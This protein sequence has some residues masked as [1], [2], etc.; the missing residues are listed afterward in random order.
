M[1]PLVLLSLTLLVAPAAAQ[2]SRSIPAGRGV[3]AGTV[4][5]RETGR[6]L[7]DAIV[8]LRSDSN[9]IL[10]TTSDAEG[11]YMFE[12]LAAGGYRVSADIDGYAHQQFRVFGNREWPGPGDLRVT[13]EG[14]KIS[15]GIAWLGLAD[16]QRRHNV[17]LAMTRG[18]HLMGRV[19]NADGRPVKDA[20]VTAMFM[21]GDGGFSITERT[22]ARTNDRGEY[23]LR[24]IAPGAYTV[25]AM[26]H[27]PDRL[28]SSAPL[29]TRPTFF[30]GTS[31]AHEAMTITVAGGATVRNI[32]IPLTPNDLFRVSGH[33]LRARSE[34]SI[35][36][37][38][39]SGE[40]A[41]RSVRVGEDGAFD[42]T[43][44]PPG[45]HTLW[46][47]AATAD[48]WEAAH[49]DLSLGSDMIGLVLP[50]TPTGTI[51]GRV[52][53]ED[54]A[55]F[56]GDGTQLIADLVDVEG[57]R[58]DALPRDRVDIGPDGAFA[59]TGMFGHRKLRLS[60][61]DF[62]VARV[63]VEK[64]SVDVL[65]VA[66]DEQIDQVLVVIQKKR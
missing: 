45:R 40:A 49:V 41:V 35:E 39:L 22:H 57:H 59:L 6:P 17:D 19:T 14:Y 23:V 50:M 42:V 54:G 26:W 43:H 12:G 44:I 46:A 52:V 1:L 4:V 48:G 60:G 33:V 62:A 31:K 47:R 37:H 16:G 58:L 28:K 55:A 3:I 13:A 8:T 10:K 18:G 9:G 51:V 38:L 2:D 32:D 24:D 20:Q 66:S 29:T 21:L 15:G 61:N 53:M 5:D 7:P 11:R 56:T 34:G 65:S 36:A 64:R 25:S 30:P 27:D 63:F